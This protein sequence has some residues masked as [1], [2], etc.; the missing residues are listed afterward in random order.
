[1]SEFNQMSHRCLHTGGWTF[2]HPGA[3]TTYRLREVITMIYMDEDMWLAA[4]KIKTRSPIP[5]VG[6]WHPYW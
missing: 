1:M 4:Q 5:N 6:A 2:H 3:N